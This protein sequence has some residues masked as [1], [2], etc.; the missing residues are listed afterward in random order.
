MIDDPDRYLSQSQVLYRTGY[1]SRSSLRR[2]C[3]KQ[4]F[5]LPLKLPSGRLV[6]PEQLVRAW[7]QQQR[8]Q[9]L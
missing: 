7:Q 8:Q 1:K 4:Q 3:L 9:R 6:W 2:L 5:P